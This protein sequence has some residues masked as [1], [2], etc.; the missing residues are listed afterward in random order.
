[1][2]TAKVHSRKN[3]GQHVRISNIVKNPSLRVIYAHRVKCREQ[4]PEH[5]SLSA[6]YTSSVLL[7]RSSMIVPRSDH[8]YEETN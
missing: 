8:S 6:L 4:V 5:A 7:V 3:K 1:M 2:G